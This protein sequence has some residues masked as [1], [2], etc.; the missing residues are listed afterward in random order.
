MKREDRMQ[1]AA[2]KRFIKR[3]PPKRCRYCESRMID[4]KGRARCT[5]QNSAKYMDIVEDS[6][7]CIEWEKA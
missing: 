1:I 6:D 4:A 5:Q 3:N 2:L 7:T